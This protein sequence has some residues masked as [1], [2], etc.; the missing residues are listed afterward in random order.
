MQPNSVA[1]LLGAKPVS[2]SGDTEYRFRQNSDF[3]YLTGFDHPNAAALLRNTDPPQYSLF[4][5][6]RMRE[7]EIW[8]GYRPGVEGALA[9]YAADKAYPINDFLVQLHET[10][11][12]VDCVYH[13]LGRDAD[14]DR[15]I[16]ESI[17][18]LRSQSRKGV[19]VP[20][21]IIDLRTLVHEMRLLKTADE[22][23]KMRKAAEIT[24]I[25]HQA[26]AK[27]AQPGRFEYEIEAMIDYTFRRHGAIGPAYTTIV[28]G[29]VNATVLHYITNAAKLR[30]GEL[31]LIDAGCEWQGY[32][33]DV[34]RTYPVGG[35]YQ[36]EKRAL[37]EVVL[38]AEHAGIEVA[39]PGATLKQIHEVVVQKITEGLVNLDILQ[40][41]I[42]ELIA[43]RAYEPYYMHSTS[44]WLGLDVHDVGAYTVS[45]ETR[46]LAPGMVFTVEPGL[47]IAA[48]AKIHQKNFCGIGVR[49]EDNLH[50][51]DDGYEILTAAI[52]KKITDVEA[53]M[54][55]N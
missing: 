20:T 43:A 11:Q 22:I 50:I 21:Q 31:V 5:E 24:Y 27:L 32:A 36:G 49:I 25:A 41:N 4:V 10:L 54:R 14:V 17:E 47:Y 26:A 12:N 19:S 9:E 28:G 33:S 3:L 53:W 6:P 55:D 18:T 51:T 34:T 23:A 52:P 48:D 40:G 8:T 1:V 42:S 2:R 46:K 39:K 37:Y 13:V 7:R 29:G 16:I 30:D 15:K 35:R 38:A 44:H 45:R